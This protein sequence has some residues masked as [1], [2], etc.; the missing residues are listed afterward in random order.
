MSENGAPPGAVTWRDGQTGSDPSRIT[1]VCPG[2]TAPPSNPRGSHDRIVVT[3]TRGEHSLAR[4]G[5]LS[6]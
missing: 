4:P 5:G 3:S 6:F 2:L 1:G